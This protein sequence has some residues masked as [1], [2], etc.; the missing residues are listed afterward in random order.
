MYRFDYT[1]SYQ[2]WR[3]NFQFSPTFTNTTQEAV[4]VFS[5]PFISIS[6]LVFP[7]DKEYY[8][9]KEIQEKIKTG[10]ISE[11][12]KISD[13]E[14]SENKS[15]EYVFFKPKAVAKADGLIVI[16][17]GLNEKEWVKYFPWASYLCQKTQKAV[18]LFP[19]A[20]HI[21]RAM[22]AWSNTRLMNSLSQERCALFP[23]LKESSFTNAAMSTRLHF[24]PSRFFLSGLETYNDVLQLVM[25]IKMGNH[26][27]LQNDCTIDFLGY[28]AGALLTEVLLMANRNNMFSK[29]RGILFCGGTVLSRMKLTSKYIMDSEAHQTI[30][31]FYVEKLNENLQ[32]DALLNM[33]FESANTGATY[34]KSLLNDQDEKLNHTRQ[35]RLQEIG[36]RLM[37]VSLTQDH[38]MTTND[39]AHTLQNTKTTHLQHN[40]E[41]PYTHAMPFP[42]VEKHK[43]DINQAFERVFEPIAQFLC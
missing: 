29:S 14:V 13:S 5:L 31:R 19:V 4:E 20:F 37:A 7:G 40:F 12:A 26:A 35:Q 41:Y 2:Y 33:L 38:V 11:I 39:I 24:A 32:K 27:Y 3:K 8:A 42:I 9:P 18:I 21:N 28:S 10:T 16:F 34:F 22:P 6:E 15:F 17:N 23:N 25:R 30:L 1:E 43:K 36:N